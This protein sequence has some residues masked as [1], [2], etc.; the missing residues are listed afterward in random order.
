M[1]GHGHLFIYIYIR[2]HIYYINIRIHIYCIHIRI[3]FPPEFRVPGSNPEK[4][5]KITIF[6][7]WKTMRKNPEITWKFPGSGFRVPTRKNFRVPGWNPEKF[8]CSEL[9]PGKIS[10]LQPLKTPP[11][12]PLLLSPCTHIKYILR[13]VGEVADYS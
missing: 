7:S 3:G 8:P 9:E 13:N 5:G 2:I 10:G 12:P 11:L 4:P 6:P 1:A